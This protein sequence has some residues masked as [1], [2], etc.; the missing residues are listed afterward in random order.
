M[1]FVRTRPHFWCCV[2]LVINDSCLLRFRVRLEV[3][4]KKNGFAPDIT[5]VVDGITNEMSIRV[6]SVG[7]CVVNI[8]TLSTGIG[9]SQT[10]SQCETC[11]SHKPGSVL[12]SGPVW[13]L[14]VTQAGLCTHLRTSVRA[15]DASRAM[16]SSQ[17]QCQSL[18]HKLGS[19]L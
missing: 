19:V 10:G 6:L 7:I 3:V 5:F 15:C 12:I 2:L 1:W 18:W 9:I 4:E 16:Y 11:L 14:L 13:E 8:I 17:D